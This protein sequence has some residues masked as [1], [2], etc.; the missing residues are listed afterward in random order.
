MCIALFS[1]LF[2]SLLRVL[3]C[4]LS[5]GEM[6]A[7][8]IFASQPIPRTMW[9]ALHINNSRQ[10]NSILP[11]LVSLAQVSSG[12][13]RHS[14]MVTLGSGI[15]AEG[16]S[17][18]SALTHPALA[19]AVIGAAPSAEAVSLLLQILRNSCSPV[20]LTNFLRLCGVM[21]ERLRVAL[22]DH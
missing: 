21:C 18:A 4:I 16:T 15:I 3:P 19:S 5:Q 10:S 7:R 22:V 9:R 17:G 1:T 11:S 12:G 14:A 13:L 2:A 20:G 8:R 6:F